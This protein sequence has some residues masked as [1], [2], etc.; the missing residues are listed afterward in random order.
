MQAEC[1]PKSGSSPK[2]CVRAQSPCSVPEL[3][4]AVSPEAADRND[5]GER[6]VAVTGADLSHT[7]PQCAGL[8]YGYAR[9][10][11]R[12]TISVHRERGRDHFLSE[13]SR[14]LSQRN[15]YSNDADNGCPPNY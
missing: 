6:E 11:L 9:Q 5:K 15:P 13:D 8:A 12:S 4:S 10:M 2:A 7:P 1:V 3:V 14:T